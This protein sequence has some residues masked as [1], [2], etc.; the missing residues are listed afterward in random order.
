MKK[1]GKL[2]NLLIREYGYVFLD[3]IMPENSLRG[4]L[5]AACV[6]AI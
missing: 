6:K 2:G 3:Q 1:H 4:S 5:D